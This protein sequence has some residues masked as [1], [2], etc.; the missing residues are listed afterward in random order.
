MGIP[1]LEARYTPPPMRINTIPPITNQR[2]IFSIF[3]LVKRRR[4][5]VIGPLT[6]DSTLKQSL[7]SFFLPVQFQML[8]CRLGRDASLSGAVEEAK[9]EEIWL[10]D[11]HDRVLLLTDRSSDG[12]QADR[13]AAVFLDDG[14]EH[15]TVDIVQTKR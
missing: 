8:V 11:V 9:L 5:N 7:L 15:A 13:T 6:F 10:D 3:I 2:A 1:N 14:F 4:L 12:V